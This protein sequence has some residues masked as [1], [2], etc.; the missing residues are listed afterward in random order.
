M[1]TTPTTATAWDAFWRRVDSEEWL[2]ARA[3]L[4]LSPALHREATS[5]V[6]KRGHDGLHDWIADVDNN[7]RG[8]SSTEAR[9]FRVVAALVDPYPDRD[10][11]RGPWEAPTTDGGV[12]RVVAVTNFLELMGSWEGDV[13]RI[14]TEW[15]TGGNNRDV[16]G[17]ATVVA[18]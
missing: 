6:E 12:R 14:L 11:P 4:Q 8:W 3:L 5:W 7:G 16:S 17:R 13:W 10:E 2:T 15:G 1:T 18:R 9:L